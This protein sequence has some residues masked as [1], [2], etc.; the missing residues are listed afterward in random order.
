MTS[1]VRLFKF[2]LLLVVGVGL[3]FGRIS[4]IYADGTSPETPTVEQNPTDEVDIIS[5]ERGGSAA[6]HATNLTLAQFTALDAFNAGNGDKLVDIEIHWTGTDARYSGIWYPVAGTIYTLVQEPYSGW[7]T[8]FTDMGAKNGRFLDVEVGY[9]GGVKLYSAIFYED[10]DDY[11]FSLRT[12]NSDSQFQTHIANNYNAGYSIIDFE[13]Y[14]DGS[15]DTKYAG[16]WVADPNQP[17]TSLYYGLEH[18]DVSQLVNPRI[19]RVID[20]EHYYSSVHGED[21]WAM[22]F[23]MDSG[24]TQGQWRNDT[25]SGIST[26]NT[27]I[28]DSNTHIIDIESY[29]VNGSVLYAALWGDTFK[30]LHE[31]DLI[32]SDTNNEATGTIIQN[33]LTSF[34]SG[35]QGIIGLYAKNVRTNQSIMYRADEPFYMASSAKIPIH[36][37]YWREVQN[38]HLD[39]NTSIAFT[40]GTNSRSPWY[41]GDRTGGLTRSNFGQSF[42]LQQYDAFMMDVSD[43][44][45]TTVLMDDPN[46]GLTFDGYDINEWLADISGVGQGWGLVT[47]IHDVDRNILWQGQVNDAPSAAS[48]FPAPGWALEAWVRES[49]PWSDLQNYF[50]VTGT[51][52]LPGYNLTAGYQR[53]F[54][55]GLNSAT[56]R[57]S[58]LLLEKLVEGDLLD[59]TNT[60]NAIQSMTEGSPFDWYGSS[61][62]WPSHV[63]IWAKGGNKG[64]PSDSTQV[65]N[66]VAI[67]DLG[68]DDIVVSILTENNSR[69]VFNNST[70]FPPI[71][72]GI[73]A[74]FIQPLGEA[75]LARL[76]ADLQTCRLF[77]F[78]PKTV[79][80]G[81]QFTAECTVDNL[82]GGATPEFDVSFYASPN[83]SITSRFDWFLGSATIGPIDAYGQESFEVTLTVPANISI[84]EY[85]FGWIVDSDTSADDLGEVGELDESNNI[86]YDTFDKLT[87]AVPTAVTVNSTESS[88]AP[89]IFLPLLIIVTLLSGIVW[90][91]KRP[92]QSR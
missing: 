61:T 55:Q 30:S 4:P 63:N 80:A 2:W 45:G 40:S 83:E 33:L 21:R 85:F 10:G 19:G 79:P 58:T 88:P 62:T 6:S 28:S 84:N 86:G 8:F 36:L 64:R 56:P 44:A 16:V 20:I 9:F 68:P 18:D 66:D 35:G 14:V 31:V 90:Q 69:P 60:D 75:V 70:V 65:S 78:S 15:G 42:T 22:I 87:V 52:N 37:K 5:A 76:S 7:E 51:A 25:A 91:N 82:G 67:F 38:G 74:T 54:A 59:A 71:T 73:R 39:P 32:P 81:G 53:Y 43:N 48:Y 12:T 89:S 41:T 57:A 26:F 27:S 29:D 24:G 77:D 46:S 17:Q 49:D 11:A 23:A 1:L 50:G 47:S 72:N 92:Q 3:F 13:A 34:E